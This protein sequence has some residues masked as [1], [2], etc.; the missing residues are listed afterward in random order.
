MNK[1]AFIDDKGLLIGWAYSNEHMHYTA[2]EVPHDFNLSPLQF[3][4][5]NGDWIPYTPPAQQVA[6]IKRWFAFWRK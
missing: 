4:Y 1:H 3:R 5:S 6:K 2:I